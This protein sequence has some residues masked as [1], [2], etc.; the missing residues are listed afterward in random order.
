MWILDNEAHT[1]LHAA[2]QLERAEVV[3][4]LD[5]EMGKQ[6]LLNPK[7]VQRQQEKEL[8][9]M[10]KRRKAVHKVQIEWEKQ[11]MRRRRK[12]DA[13]INS[14]ETGDSAWRRAIGTIGRTLTMKSQR[15]NPQSQRDHN[16]R[17]TRTTAY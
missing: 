17:A 13:R 11:E 8:T 2:H 3:Q 14:S 7:T 15:G 5:Y 9:I 16:A 1:A 4:F 6:R 10:E 12:L